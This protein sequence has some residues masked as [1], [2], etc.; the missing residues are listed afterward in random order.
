MFV[1]W[2]VSSYNSDMFLVGILSWWYGNGWS[3]RIQI[4]KR[5]LSSSA[6]FFSVGM[7]VSTIF[8]PYRQISA[9]EVD[10]S[11]KVHLQAFVDR[12][13]SRFVGAFIR[14][15]MIII[16]LF[17]MLFQVILGIIIIILWPILPVFIVIGLIL[18]VIGWVPLWTI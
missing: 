8:A 3:A 12:T 4:I 16:G 10:G 14:M 1:L 11:L 17:A 6:D 2:N 13:I 7:L 9:G 18:M 15:F 5:Q